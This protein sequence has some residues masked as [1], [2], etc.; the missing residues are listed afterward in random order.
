MTLVK[1]AIVWDYRL[2]IVTAD[3]LVSETSWA[4]AVAALRRE[5]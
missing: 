1:L 2:M 5:M 4:L 3:P